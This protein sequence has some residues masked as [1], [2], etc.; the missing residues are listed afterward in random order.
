MPALDA[1]LALEQMQDVAVDVA[2][3]LHLDVAGARDVF[4]D[5]QIGPAERSL[6]LGRA[7]IPRLPQFGRMTHHTHTATAAASHRLHHHP[8]AWRKLPHEGLSRVEAGR[9]L[10]PLRDG[11]AGLPRRGE[12]PHLVAE[13]AKH[14][15]RRPDEDEAGLCAE[16]REV[17]AFAEETGIQDE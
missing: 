14:L 17:G 10:R 6:C 2:D 8:G 7:A 12:G 11:D 1:A 5:I 4:L 3:D 13:R 15:G 16:A 9:P